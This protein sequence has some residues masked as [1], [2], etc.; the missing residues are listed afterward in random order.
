M[1]LLRVQVP[2]SSQ[3]LGT[4]TGKLELLGGRQN[5]PPGT[6]MA[7]KTPVHSGLLDTKG[8]TRSMCLSAFL[9]GF[10]FAGSCG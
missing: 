9:W 3:S 2:K 6:P 7:V 4:L 5:S 1:V 10:T 8:R